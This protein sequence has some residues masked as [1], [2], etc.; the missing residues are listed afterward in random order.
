MAPEPG[1]DDPGFSTVPGVDPYIDWALGAGRAHFFLRGR[2]QEWM[3]VLLRLKGISARDFAAGKFFGEEEAEKRK[4]WLELI[5]VSPLYL[6]APA[7]ADAT[8]YCTA[9]AREGFFEFMKSDEQIREVVIGVTLGLPLDAES[10]PA[11]EG[12][13]ILGK[14]QP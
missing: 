12:K 13:L 4:R 5:H 2:Q 6:D 11:S 8:S 7:R 14:D 3:P 9:M 1:N 10:L